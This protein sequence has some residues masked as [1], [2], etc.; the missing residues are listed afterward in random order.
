M[1]GR[2]QVRIYVT[3]IGGVLALWV[4]SYLKGQHVGQAESAAFGLLADVV[5]V[6]LAAHWL[7]DGA[8]RFRRYRRIFDPRSQYEGYWLATVGDLREREHAIGV[9][10][11]NPHSGN[12]VYSGRALD[13]NFAVAATWGSSNVEI[14]LDQDRLRYLYHSNIGL[15]SGSVEGFGYIY[16]DRTPEGDIDT[17]RGFFVDVESGAGAHH[18]HYTMQRIPDSLLK[19]IRDQDRSAW[20]DVDAVVASIARRVIPVRAGTTIQNP[21]LGADT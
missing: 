13:E 3:A 20:H 14:D 1:D 7:V 5:F 15:R 8:M 16:F 2:S 6:G 18:H 4:Y 17:A 21:R 12:Y 10:S 19:E 11:Y 9:L